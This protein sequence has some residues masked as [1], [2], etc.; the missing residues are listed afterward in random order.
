M[1]NAN[2]GISKPLW[3]L[4]ALYTFA[5]LVHFVHN[6]EFIAFYPNMP[7]WIT[8]TTVY[9]AWLGI[10]AIGIVGIGFWKI[11]WYVLGAV[12]VAIYGALGI[13]GLA[14]YSLALCSEHTFAANATIW[15]EVL[16]GTALMLTAGYKAYLALMH[17]AKG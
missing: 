17:R 11:G 13:D 2:N 3:S 6:A 7:Q 4:I 15:F 16:T 1:K 5:S 12:F 10:A 8:S 9:K 14:H